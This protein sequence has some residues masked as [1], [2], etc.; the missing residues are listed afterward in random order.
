MIKHNFLYI[1]VSFFLLTSCIE[2]NFKHEVVAGDGEVSF[3]AS[4]GSGVT[5]K[6]MYGGINPETEN[7]K[8]YWVH[9]DRIT[10]FGA[11]LGSRAQ[12]DYKVSVNTT[13]A[14]GNVVKPQQTYANDLV[15]AGDYGVQW[16]NGIGQTDF[17]AIYPSTQNPWTYTKASSNNDGIVATTSATVETSIN[18]EQTLDFYRSPDGWK[19]IHYGTDIH[20]PSA[21]NALMY[22]CTTG[23]QATDADGNPKTIDLRFYPFTTILRFNFAGFNIEVEDNPNAGYTPTVY[24]NKITLT[25]PEKIAGKFN[26]TITPASNAGSKPNATASAGSSNTITI[27]P[28]TQIPL[29]ANESLEFDVFTVPRAYTM[30]ATNKT[31]AYKN[32]WQVTL[33]TSAGKFTYSLIPKKLIRTDDE[34][35]PIYEYIQASLQAGKIHNL[36]I[37]VQTVVRPPIQVP[38]DSW[39]AWIP[40]NVYLSELSIPGA[41]YCYDRNYQGNDIVSDGDNTDSDKADD[42]KAGLVT[43]Y[44]KGVRAFHIDC[45]LTYK[46]GRSG[47]MDLYCSGTEESSSG[48]TGIT[49]NTGV[50]VSTAMSQIASLIQEDEYVVVVLTI[51]EVHKTHSNTNLGTVAPNKVL[52]AIY[53]MLSSNAENWNIYNPDGGIH[54]D[55]ILQDV[56]GHMVVKINVNTSDENLSE[57]IGNSQYAL[58]SE[59]SLASSDDASLDIVKGTFNDMVAAPMYWGASLIGGE[60]EIKN[61]NYYY[62]QAQLTTDDRIEESSYDETVTSSETGPTLKNRIDAIDKIMDNSKRIYESSA[63]NAWFQ[64]ATGGTIKYERRVLVSSADCDVHGKVANVLNGHLLT[65]IDEKI[66]SNEV[67][68]VGIVLMNYAAQDSVDDIYYRDVVFGNTTDTKSVTVS[69]FGPSLVSK[70]LELNK[71]FYLNRNP[72]K[73]EWPNG[74]PFDPNKTKTSERIKSV[75]VIVHTL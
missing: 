18:P 3:S 2:E 65:K 14:N 52:P 41:W 59:G 68:P 63:H 39:I 72:E 61:M 15:K 74:S 60:D 45:R 66:A 22:A 46:S 48:T 54:S 25:S 62:H 17:Y 35:G 8:V 23:A 26:L 43:L 58:V 12:A 57:M 36:N 67:S 33:E 6:T 38:D 37:P 9:D 73:P 40:R 56:L 11:G 42:I 71:L 27:T 50:L 32:P 49:A 64:I 19:G 47:D 30:G 34:N 31:D 21:P 53:S 10:V 24:V 55:T 75:D 4:V 16:G 51:A 5:T 20:N 69:T 13:D 44:N 70:V 7:Q 28:S 29:K 1:L